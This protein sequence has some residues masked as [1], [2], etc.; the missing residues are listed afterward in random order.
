MSLA[1]TSRTGV[2]TCRRLTEVKHSPR[3]RCGTHGIA[4]LNSRER[5]GWRPCSNCYARLGSRCGSLGNR[6]GLCCRDRLSGSS[7]ASGHL[8]TVALKYRVGT[9]IPLFVGPVWKGRCRAPNPA[10]R[11]HDIKKGTLQ[12]PQQFGA[13]FPTNLAEQDLPMV[14]LCM[15]TSGAF[16]SVLGVREFATVRPADST[17]KLAETSRVSRWLR[18]TIGLQSRHCHFY[19]VGTGICCK[20]YEL[21][22][23]RGVKGVS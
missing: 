3:T 6:V 22:V 19:I 7:S 8:V 18:G 17:S 16:G 11:L 9:G 20:L 21:S 1:I 13:P 14:R 10:L 4:G 12:V 5:I 23:D 15:K 2:G